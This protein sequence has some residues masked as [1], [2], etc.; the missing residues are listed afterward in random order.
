MRACYQFSLIT[1]WRLL[2]TLI[3]R[4]LLKR[5][6]GSQPQSQSQSPPTGSKKPRK[7]RQIID[8]A[9]W[10]AVEGAICVGGLGYSEAGRKFGIEPH[11]IMGKARR[12]A[13]PVPSMIQK[14]VEILQ[15]ARYK[16]REHYKPYEETRN[17][18]EEVIEAAAT[19][20]AEKGEMHRALAFNLA[21]GALAAAAR[22]GGCQSRPGVMRIWPI[23]SP[24]KH[25]ASITRTQRS[26]S[27]WPS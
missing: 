22:T 23:R 3:A 4:R 26:I 25:A 20:L 6:M 12:N 5:G 15:A 24:G 18:N 21:N 17:G 16:A 1:T 14:R 19:I 2:Q 10:K 11:A 27:I 9:T 13:W 8:D 7:M